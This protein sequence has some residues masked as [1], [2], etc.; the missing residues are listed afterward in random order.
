[1]YSSTLSLAS[2]LDRSGWSTPRP[3]RFNPGKDPE[4]IVQEAGWVPQP[5]WTDTENLAS[6]GIRS[7]DRPAR[8]ESLYRLN[9]C[10]PWRVLCIFTC[11]LNVQ[12]RPVRP[13][14]WTLLQI[15]CKSLHYFL[16]TL[17]PHYAIAIN[18]YRVA[19]ILTYK[20]RPT[21][22]SF[23]AEPSFLYGYH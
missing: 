2:A 5:A 22:R 6:T 3:G 10:G 15:I 4:P 23:F 7:P 16:N 11:A 13:S 18:I 12:C 21:L 9:C 19:M 8:N 17:Q 20:N 14:T 1:M